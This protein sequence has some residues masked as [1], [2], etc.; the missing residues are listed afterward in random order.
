VCTAAVADHTLLWPPNHKYVTIK[1]KGV[2]DPDGDAVT[3][4]VTQIWQDESTM[5]DG[6]GDT[7]I[8]GIIDGST[9]RVRAE[10]A[11]DGDGRIYQIFFRATDALGACEGSVTVGVPHDQSGAPAF[12]SGVRYD[13][14]VANGGPVSGTPPNRKPVAKADKASTLKGAPTTIA[15]LAND[16]DPDGHPLSIVSATQGMHGTVV[17]NVNGTITYTPTSRYEGTDSFT[18]TVSDDHGGTA[19]A[20]VTVTVKKHFDGDDCEHDHHRGGR[21]DDDD[22]DHDRDTRR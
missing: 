13:S 12:D 3:L 16:S 9:A 6:S 17:V 14:T 10:R 8:D 22:S 5:A 15:V 11:G 20:T 19:T 4:A 7:P 21:H 18:Y 1:I 2:T